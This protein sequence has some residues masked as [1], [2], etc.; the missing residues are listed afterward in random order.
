MTLCADNLSKVT[1]V[2]G[3]DI[4]VN[5]RVWS[6][7]ALCPGVIGDRRVAGGHFIMRKYMIEALLL[8]KRDGIFNI[9]N[10]KSYQTQLIIIVSQVKLNLEGVV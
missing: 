10:I 8:L 9:S 5:I 3:L 1:S 6:P 7:S 4:N 2:L